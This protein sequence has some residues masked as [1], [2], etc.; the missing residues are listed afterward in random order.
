SGLI[1]SASPTKTFDLSIN[2]SSPTTI[3]LLTGFSTSPSNWINSSGNSVS[4]KSQQNTF[5]YPGDVMN[6]TIYFEVDNS[7]LIGTTITNCANYKGSIID[8]VNIINLSFDKDNC[9]SFTVESPIV[10]L[11]AIKE[12]RKANTNNAFASSVTNI[13]PTD[14]LEFK[15]CI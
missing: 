13:V 5:L 6:I 3:S 15:I 1:N 10:K 8:T 11:C 4:I 14:E 2:N 7:F 9:D 12:V